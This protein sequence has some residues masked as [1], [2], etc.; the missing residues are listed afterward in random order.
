MVHSGSCGQ[1]TLPSRW[2]QERNSESDPPI[3]LNVFYCAVGFDNGA[4]LNQNR[5]HV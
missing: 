4:I 1:K 2:A 5:Q 3:L